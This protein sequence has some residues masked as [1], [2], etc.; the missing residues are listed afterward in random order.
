[1]AAGRRRGKLPAALRQ[2]QSP[3]DPRQQIK[4]RGAM[5]QMGEMKIDRDKWRWAN[6]AKNPF[7]CPDA[8]AAKEWGTYLDDVRKQG[9]SVGAVIEIV[10]SG[11]PAGLGAPIYGKL[12][13][14]LAAAM[15]SI[16]AVHGV[17]WCRLRRGRVI[18][19]KTMPTKCG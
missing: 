11:V 5:V 8:A 17:N 9:S 18:G 12:D 10:A 6:I 1:M 13:A 16:N 15:M 4:I 3:E 7:W 2:V 19:P 14:D